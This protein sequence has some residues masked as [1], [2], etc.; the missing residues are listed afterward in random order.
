MLALISCFAMRE[1][2]RGT[3]VGP[4][5]CGSVRGDTFRFHMYTTDV[6]QAP[7]LAQ[8][9]LQPFNLAADLTDLV[10]Q[11]RHDRRGRA[12]ALVVNGHDGLDLLQRA[13]EPS[14]AGHEP[15]ADQVASLYS[16]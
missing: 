13:P 8:D 15:D 9:L 10:V 3:L 2:I 6:L 1:M 14:R 12:G 7:Q 4:P 5:M 11:K 16:R